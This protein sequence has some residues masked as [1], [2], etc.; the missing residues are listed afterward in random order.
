LREGSFTGIDVFRT[1]PHNIEARVDF[2]TSGI[3]NS[4]VVN[5][6]YASGSG[7]LIFT[8]TGGT[9]DFKQTIIVTGLP[10]I[11][12]FDDPDHEDTEVFFLKLSNPRS[13]SIDVEITGVNPYPVFILEDKDPH[14]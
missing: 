3:E 11:D 5:E 4:A 8:N 9:G 12:S 6:D 7:T 1:E 14:S 2:T 13:S 10:L